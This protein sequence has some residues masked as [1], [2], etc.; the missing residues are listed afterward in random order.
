MTD[1]IEFHDQMRE[2]YAQ[3]DESRRR[4]RRMFF[5]IYLVLPQ[6]TVGSQTVNHAHGMV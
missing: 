2:H 5:W 6:S 1:Y 3:R 4:V